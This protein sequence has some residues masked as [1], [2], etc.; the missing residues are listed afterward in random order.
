MNALFLIIDHNNVNSIG[1]AKTIYKEKCEES[2]DHEYNI[3]IYQIMAAIQMID[4][5]SKN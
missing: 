3:I 1:E 2:H 5:W 4:S